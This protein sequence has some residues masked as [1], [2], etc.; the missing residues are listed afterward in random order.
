MFSR[1]GE[2]SLCHVCTNCIPTLLACQPMT[3]EKNT[4]TVLI[5]I[6]RFAQ[7]L[8]SALQ[9]RDYRLNF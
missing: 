7:V 3:D 8:T 6:I 2:R 5:R 4:V 9:G 1:L